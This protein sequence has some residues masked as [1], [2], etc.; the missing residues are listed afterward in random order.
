MSNDRRPTDRRALESQRKFPRKVVSIPC[1]LKVGAHEYP[2]RLRDLSIG[3]AFVQ[4]NE[5]ITLGTILTIAVTQGRKKAPY[6][7]LNAKA[8]YSGRFIQGFNNFNG[9]GAAF[10]DP[11]PEDI[12]KL[13]EIIDQH[14][15]DPVQKFEFM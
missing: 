3:G 1:V 5:F 2:A 6:L 15:D 8:I 10:I 11:S 13:N 7:D 4:T 14:I 9:F 12:A